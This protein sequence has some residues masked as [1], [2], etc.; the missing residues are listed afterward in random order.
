M[1]QRK[2]LVFTEAE[3][4]EHESCPHG[5]VSRPTR[6]FDPH[7]KREIELRR[8]ADGDFVLSLTL[9]ELR[10][11]IIIVVMLKSHINVLAR[12]LLDGHYD[13]ALI[14]DE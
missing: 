6:K 13:P 7:T 1:S 14:R 3:L 8:R 2:A 11:S 4:D 9:A 5:Y 12:V 10:N